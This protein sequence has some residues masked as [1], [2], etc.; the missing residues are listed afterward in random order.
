MGTAHYRTQNIV[1]NMNDLYQHREIS[2]PMTYV[3][4]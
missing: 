3:I 2:S 4:D 1:V